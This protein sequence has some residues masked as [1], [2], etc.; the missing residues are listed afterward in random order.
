MQEYHGITPPDEETKPVIMDWAHAE[1]YLKEMKKAYEE[2][3]PSGSLAL[4]LFLKP[5]YARFEIGE[6]TEDLYNDILSI[7]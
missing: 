3:G 7:Q 5:I 6:R 2:A 4:N 1:E